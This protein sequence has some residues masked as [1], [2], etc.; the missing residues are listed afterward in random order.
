MVDNVK[1]IE[2]MIVVMNS[3]F[4]APRRAYIL[5]PNPLSPKALPSPASDL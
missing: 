3:V 4:S 2:I 5:P 1:S